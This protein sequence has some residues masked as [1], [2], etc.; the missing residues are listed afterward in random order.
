MESSPLDRPFALSLSA[1]PARRSVP[2]AVMVQAMVIVLV[3]ANLGRI[4]LV[5]TGDREAPLLVNDLAVIAMVMMGATACLTARL[6]RVDRIM[7]A[8]AAFVM[9]GA[10]S[11]F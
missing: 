10:G 5:S 6:L 3:T 4:P 1:N 7:L 11:A 9:L 8:A 2:L